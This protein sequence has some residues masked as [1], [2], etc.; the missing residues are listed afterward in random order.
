MCS[1]FHE[2]QA[3]R[4]QNKLSVAEGAAC[5]LV[6]GAAPLLHFISYGVAAAVNDSLQNPSIFLVFLFTQIIQ[7]VTS[8]HLQ[9][10]IQ[11]AKCTWTTGL[12]TLYVRE[13]KNKQKT[14]K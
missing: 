11:M 13:K 2:R 8:H 10:W 1:A 14:Y 5:G 9:Y 6:P 3:D 7:T 4:E 12:S